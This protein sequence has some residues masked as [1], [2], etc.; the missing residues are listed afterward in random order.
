MTNR[1]RMQEI[2]ELLEYGLQ[3]LMRT[4]HYQEWLK[5][6]SHFHTY[7]LHNTVLIYTQCPNATYV[8]G[9]RSWQKNFQRQVKKGEKGIRII[10]PMTYPQK[11]EEEVLHV[12]RVVSVFDISQTTGETLPEIR[13]KELTHKLENYHRLYDTITKMSPIPICLEDIPNGAKGYFDC[14]NQKIGI[15]EG[16][17]Q[18]QTI[19]T[20]I[21][22]L[23]HARVHQHSDLP[24]EL[25]EVQAESIAFTVCY[26]FGLDTS[27]YSFP[28][29]AKWSQDA[30]L[31]L[32]QKSLSLIVE[33]ASRM[34]QEMESILNS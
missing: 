29:I 15:Q 14:R 18:A 9:Y 12:F 23:A 20:L 28:Y 13:V 17:S 3:N 16:M 8:A 34:V 10:A 7:S 19:K 26:R 4:N 25:K 27:S 31:S 33:E 11:E 1:E 5:T 21:H 24:R 6:M 30:N 2:A 22:E 32:F